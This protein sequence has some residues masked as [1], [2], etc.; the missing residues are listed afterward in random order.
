MWYEYF[1]TRRVLDNRG[2]SFSKLIVLISRIAIALSLAVMIISVSLVNGFRSTISDKIYGF[3]GH[4]NV[5]KESL[6]NSY[7]DEPI[8]RSGTFINQVMAIHGVSNVQVYARKAAI[9]QTK[10][11]IEGI[12]LKGIGSDYNWD[13]FRQYFTAGTSIDLNDSIPSDGIVLSRS[14]AERMKFS[15]GDTVLMHFIDQSPT[16]DYLQRYKKFVVRGIYN[17]GLDEFDKLFALVDI[18]LIQQLNNWEPWQIGGYEV[19]VKNNDD[20]DKLA[21]H[22]DAIAD[23][24]WEVQTI[25]E[26]IP[27]VFDWLNLQKVNEWIILTLMLTVAIIN[28]VTS[29]LILILERTH[30]IG[31]LKALGSRTASIRRIFLLNAAYIIFWGMLLGNVL[32]LGICLIQKYFGVIRLPEQ[33]YYVSVAPVSINPWLVIGLNILTLVVSLLFLII[34]SYLVAR[35]RPIRAIHFN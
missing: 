23:P 15:V 34:P 28:M 24:F 11:D 32:G 20:L 6:R 3:W 17:T 12:I 14:T 1:I 29:L 7:D 30:M 35:I 19:F 22:V 5:S 2:K 10:S 25:H 4:I 21:T 18:R 13:R 9:I 16:G 33:S 31:I 8:Q 27:S 26:L